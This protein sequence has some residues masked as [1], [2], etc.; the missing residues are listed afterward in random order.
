[1]RT[2][3]VFGGLAMVLV[4]LTLTLTGLAYAS[5]P[6]PTWN[7]G[8]YDDADFDDVVGYLTSASGLVEVIATPDLRPGDVLVIPLLPSPGRIVSLDPPAARHPR[9]PP[10]V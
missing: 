7:R 9:A 5:P 2:R 4:A 6:D 1:M 8:M 3:I 10:T